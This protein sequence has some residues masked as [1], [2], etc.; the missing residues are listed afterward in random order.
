MDNFIGNKLAK[1]KESIFEHT[2]KLKKSAEILY[3]FGYIKDN[4]LYHDLR[5]ACE[6][7]DYGKANS[8]FQK[9]VVAHYPFNPNTEIPHNVLSL[10]FVDEDKCRDYINVAFA[11]LYHHYHKNSPV[12]IFYD[13]EEL[14]KKFIEELGVDEST[15][16]NMY[17]CIDEIG[18]LFSLIETDPKKKNAVLLK[19]FLHKCDYSASANIRCEYPND[20]L[21]EQI[22]NWKNKNDITF[23]SLQQFCLDNTDKDIVVTAPTGMGKTEAGL[24]W[25]G[26]NKCFFVLPLRTAINAMYSRIKALSGSEYKNRVALIHSDMKSYYFND[27]KINSSGEFDFDYCIRSRQMSLP[28]TVCTPDQIFDFA[29]KFAG[30]E[31][32]LATA[33]YSKF[34]IDEIQMYSPDILAVIIYAIK[35]IHIMGGKIA[36]L[37]ATLPPFVKSE[38]DKILGTE[39]V[40]KDF[41]DDG[42]NRHNVSVFEK[43]LNSDDVAELIKKTKSDRVKKFLIVCNSIDTANRIFEELSKKFEDEIEVNLFHARF[44]KNDRAVK[45]QQIFEASRDRTKTEIWVSTSV[46]EASLDIDFD[47][48]FTELSDLFSLFQRFGRVNRKGKKD[49]SNTNCYVF[50]ELQGNAKKF[51][52]TDDTVYN[53]S[54]Q[55]TLTMNC[56]ISESEKTKLIEEYLSTENLKESNYVKEYR[57]NFEYLEHLLDYEKDSSSKLRS[58]DNVDV[59]PLSVFSENEEKINKALSVLNDN[60]SSM[61]EKLEMNNLI[62]GHTVSVPTYRAKNAKKFLYAQYQR[63]PILENCNYSFQG[64]L[65]MLKET[66]KPIVDNFL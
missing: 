53:Y 4:D 38:L 37:T 21:L 64:G 50:T 15:Y 3:N 35:M 36:I 56:V 24:L 42:I 29:L 20:F 39:K 62:I 32:K 48:L 10:F 14:I 8:E 45:E 11:V 2:E 51:H 28:I 16:E 54:K 23:N 43:K 22:N 57:E 19:G 9:R 30:Y 44:T 7:H 47:I 58:I 18:E 33:S 25:C 31:Y 27:S 13:E 46:V 55:A 61:E 60:N 52:F 49:F 5:V 12:D 17:D 66:T 26:D 1:P 34:I 6:Y 41:S 65:V 40:T 63:I 59:V